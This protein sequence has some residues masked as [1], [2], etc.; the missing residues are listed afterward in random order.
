MYIFLIILFID[1]FKLS[2]YFIFVLFLYL[3]IYLLYYPC[4]SLTSF[5]NFSFLPFYYLEFSTLILFFYSF[6]YLRIYC[7][8]H[9]VFSRLLSRIFSVG[10]YLNFNFSLLSLILFFP[11]HHQRHFF[12]LSYI[13]VSWRRVYRS[14]G[15]F[16]GFP[17]LIRITVF[18]P[19]FQV[20]TGAAFLA[21][22]FASARREWGPV[23]YWLLTLL[24]RSVFVGAFSQ[25]HSASRFSA[26]PSSVTFALPSSLLQHHTSL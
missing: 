15:N 23:R 24:Y 21:Y 14:G 16:A 22:L 10:F 25:H 9:S 13:C 26:L 7:S 20:S 19:F 1:I 4:P 3:P 17:P 6:I 18:L 11:L 5:S 8:C 12:S 2:F